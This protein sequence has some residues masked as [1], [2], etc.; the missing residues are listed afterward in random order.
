M[1]YTFV[2]IGVKEDNVDFS[3]NCGNISGVV[4]QGVSEK[5]QDVS[6]ISRVGTAAYVQDINS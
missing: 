5:A 3:S 1:D 2:A 4:A 6:G